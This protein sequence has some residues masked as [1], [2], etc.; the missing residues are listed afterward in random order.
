MEALYFCET[1]VNVYRTTKRHIIEDDHLHNF[2]RDIL[3]SV[4]VSPPPLLLCGPTRRRGQQVGYLAFNLGGGLHRGS[5]LCISSV[6]GSTTTSCDILGFV[7]AL[8]TSRLVTSVK[9]CIET[10]RAIFQLLRVGLI[11]LWLCKEN[12]LRD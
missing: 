11:S 2:R 1:S 9:S 5:C 12:K 10:V 6:L 4:P 7:I 3:K 8:L